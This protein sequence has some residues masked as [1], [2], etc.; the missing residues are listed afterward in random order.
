MRYV[1]FG[2]PGVGKT[3]VIDKIVE[4]TGIERINWG[5]LTEE[6]MREQ[7]LVERRDQM[8]QLPINKQ[9]P[10][11]KVVA[12]RV[13]QIAGEKEDILIE[14]HAALKTPYGFWP[15]F[16]FDTLRKI[17]PDMFIAMEA[18]AEKILERREKDKTRTRK[19]DKDTEEV[20]ESLEITRTM[21][22]SYAIMTG[23]TVIFVENKEGDLD[24]AVDHITEF[25]EKGR[26]VK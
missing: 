7:G 4:K 13:A 22:R 19:D 16:N 21:A 6:I 18:P 11:Q 20:K 1:I 5:D 15:G 8:R 2:I 9:A 26:E 12:D 10:V 14:T 25:I 3:A 24:Y 23:G 17:M